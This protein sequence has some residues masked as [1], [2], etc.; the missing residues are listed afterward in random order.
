MSLDSWVTTTLGEH[1]E[2]RKRKGIPAEQQGIAYLGLEHVESQTG[3]I[4]GIGSS[5]DYKSSSPLVDPGDVLY[6]R[7][8]PYLNKVVIAP[9][10]LFVSAE[11]IVFPPSETLDSRFLRYLL[12]SPGFLAFTAL[13]DTGDR[14][15]VSWDKIANYEFQLPPHDEQVQV[16]EALDD[17]LSR[18][19]KALAEVELGRNKEKLFKR[20]LLHSLFENL[21]AEVYELGDVSKPQYG[22]DVPKHLRGAS[23][24]YPVV[25]SAGVMTYTEVPLVERPSVLVGRKGNVGAVQM[26]TS[27]CS[28]VDT[29]YYLICP[30]DVDLEFMY[31]QL[32]SVDL[33]SLD[34]STTIPS[35][36][37]QDLEAVQFRKPDLATQ[38][39]I[40]QEIKAKLSS[41]DAALDQLGP[42]A[43]ALSLLRRSVLNAAFTGTLIKEVR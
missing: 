12:M 36:R 30:E 9:E 38:Q 40:S 25:G 24:A 13:L 8:R 35:L 18:L 32:Q 3:R 33:K 23:F 1:L 37:R 34:S 29:A 10:Q 7:L 27:P 43:A 31:F 20:S 26:F 14:P 41:I 6:G 17:H 11:F 39:A 16:V 15:R 42:I 19:D 28:P 22:K 21:D 2:P 5:A 4:Q